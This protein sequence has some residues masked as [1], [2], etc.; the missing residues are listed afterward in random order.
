MTA[1]NLP[2][3]HL[4]ACTFQPFN[5]D[6]PQACNASIQSSNSGHVSRPGVESGGSKLGQMHLGCAWIS[7]HIFSQLSPSSFNLLCNSVRSCMSLLMQA[8][9]DSEFVDFK[10]ATR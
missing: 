9:L 7:L 10:D 2:C 8:M 3:S 4:P 5:W 6:F 1:K